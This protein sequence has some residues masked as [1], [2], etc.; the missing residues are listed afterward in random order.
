MSY[1]RRSG[2]LF[3]NK[4]CFSTYDGTLRLCGEM[5]LGAGYFS[6]LVFVQLDCW[7]LAKKVF[8]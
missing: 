1:L 6:N 3:S 8:K 7:G 4:S 2:D 5:D